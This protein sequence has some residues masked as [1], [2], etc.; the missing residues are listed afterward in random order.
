MFAISKYIYVLA[1]SILINIPRSILHFC[2]I[3]FLFL[4]ILL[5][6]ANI[7]AMSCIFVCVKFFSIGFKYRVFQDTLFV[8]F[9]LPCFSCFSSSRRTVPNFRN[10]FVYRFITGVLMRAKF[11]RFPRAAGEPPRSFLAAGSL[12][13]RFFPQESRKF[14][15]H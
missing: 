5:L 3:S 2:T 14:R 6:L 7:V 8:H 11:T 10:I 15:T 9:R 4:S 1:S 13:A 12:L